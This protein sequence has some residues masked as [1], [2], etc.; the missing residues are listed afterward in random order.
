MSPIQIDGQ[1]LTSAQVAAV[2]AGAP[3]VLAEAARARMQRS[4]AAWPAEPS[5]LETKRRFLVG[6]GGAAGGD[7]VRSFVLGHCAGVGEPLPTASVRALIAC[8]ANVLATGHSGVRPELVEAM[9]RML[10]AGVIPVVPSQGSVGAAGDLAPLAH[11]ARV[12]FG[13][14]GEAELPGGGRGRSPLPAFVPTAKEALATINGATLT[15]ALSALAVHRSHRVLG[16]ALDACAMT[17]AVSHAD[18]GLLNSSLLRARGH[19]GGSVAAERMRARLGSPG[20]GVHSPDAFSLRAAPAVLGT[21]LD[22]LAWVEGTVT[23]ELNGACDNP[24]W[25]EG[26]GPVEGGNFHGAPVA[27]AMD[28]LR[29]ALT[30]VATQSER[31]T[32]RLTSASLSRDLP[33]FLVAGT[34]LNSGFML[35]QYTAASL[36]SECKGLSHP[37]SVDSIPTV[38]HHEDHVSMGPIAA[39]LTLRVLEC[40]ADIVGIEVLLAAQA[41]DWRLSGERLVNGELT[42]G[43]PEH[44]A[45]ELMALH[46]RVREVVPF[47]RDDQVMHPALRA[48]GRLVRDGLAEPEVVAW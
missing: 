33:S 7:L 42:S 20:L 11:V 23:T 22:A 45:P 14:G 34:G 43:P 48:V 5:V 18:A 10:D 30:Q 15:S 28:T 25:F 3:I 6:E 38:Q 8:R 36:A 24:L 35:A 44:F 19:A 40:V 2:A 47:W 41:L 46:A 37:A 16:A 31:R 9:A 29:I 32:F 27:L 26:E 4:A 12:L 13:F 1:T 21:A 39:R 17:L